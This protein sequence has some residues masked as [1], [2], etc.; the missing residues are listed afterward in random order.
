M[1]FL[2]LFY[3]ATSR[4]IIHL[5]DSA[6][7]GVRRHFRRLGYYA[8][9][10]LRGIIIVQIGLLDRSTAV[11]SLHVQAVCWRR[12]IEQTLFHLV[13]VRT[14]LHLFRV[15][16]PLTIWGRMRLQSKTYTKVYARHF[17]SNSHKKRKETRRAGISVRG[18][19]SV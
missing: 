10:R 2:F 19:L 11:Q 1:F 3:S 13:D 6:D 4:L 16:V 15:F 14:P 18:R 8:W 7:Q 9:I 17:L 5:D 12:L